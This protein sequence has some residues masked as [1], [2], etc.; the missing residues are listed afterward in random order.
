MKIGLLTYARPHLKT[1][2]LTEMLRR[3]HGAEV[4][5][6]AFPFVDSGNP[7]TRN[8][9]A[10]ILDGSLVEFANEH[11][12]DVV[13]VGGWGGEECAEVSGCNHYLTCISKIVPA[14][15]T[16]RLGIINAHPGLLPLA[17]G[18]DSFERSIVMRWP[19]GVTLH[20]IDEV[21]DR[22]VILAT[23]RVPI[24]P[25]DTLEE[26]A[27]RE[28]ETELKLMAGFNRFLPEK[29]EWSVGDDG[30][31]FHSHVKEDVRAALVRNKAALVESSAYGF[32]D[33]FSHPSEVRI[34]EPDNG[35]QEGIW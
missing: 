16:R 14:H 5:W 31:L 2:Q 9:P 8:R 24:F 6:F 28:Y 15:L 25:T 18:V 23:A 33:S 1:V 21:I 26:I 19:V 3:F 27:E 29:R 7:P 4:V 11:G 10:Q 12:A 34:A 32:A 30:I 20:V 13:V 17:R 22:G 35:W